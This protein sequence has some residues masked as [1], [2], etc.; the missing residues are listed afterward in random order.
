MPSP[1]SVSP[2]KPLR[3]RGKTLLRGQRGIGT[4]PHLYRFTS[5]RRPVRRAWQRLAERPVWRLWSAHDAVTPGQSTGSIDDQGG[6]RRRGQAHGKAAC[7]GRHRWVVWPAA[8]RHRG[9][10][11]CRHPGRRYPPGHPGQC[12]GSPAGRSGRHRKSR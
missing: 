6:R 1:W 8:P 4:G 3:S 2:A 7:I 11:R 10:R 5:G 9:S 12:P